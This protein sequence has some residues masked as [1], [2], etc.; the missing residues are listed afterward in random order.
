MAQGHITHKGERTRTL[1]TIVLLFFVFSFLGWC[2]EKLTFLVEYGENA[3]RGFL[4]LPFC[5]IYGSAL[6]LV[7][8]LLGVPL[9]RE[10]RYPR[11]MISLILYAVASALLATA[12]ELCVGLFFEAVEGVRLWSYHGYPH[13]FR[14]YICL[15]MS[16]A[17]GGLITVAM[18]ALWAPSER[19]LKK[20][21]VSFLAS[22]DI[23]LT[24]CVLADFLLLVSA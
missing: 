14:G 18:A 4:R 16:I 19:A 22:A 20:L 15:S 1:L 7:R 8:I 11:N 23:L 5:T 17:W 6:T 3:D 9:K 24:V 13:E 21:P 2:M 12:A 10:L